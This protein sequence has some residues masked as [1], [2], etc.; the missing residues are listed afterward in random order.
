MIVGQQ[1]GTSGPQ[2]MFNAVNDPGQAAPL[3]A[4]PL[5][6]PA[7]G[8]VQYTQDEAPPPPDY[9]ALGGQQAKADFASASAGGGWE[10]DPEAMQ[11]VIDN[12]EAVADRD[13]RRIEQDAEAIIGI[14]PP[15][16]EMVSERYVTAANNAGAEANTQFGNNIEFL[17]AYIGTLKDIYSAYQSQDEAA[18]DA[19]RGKDT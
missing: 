2:G 15:G 8:Q 19:L 18:L 5:P 9:A 16:Y 7:T 17:N 4:P 1:P 3:G 12:L 10:Y 14:D 6:L 13:F 11:G